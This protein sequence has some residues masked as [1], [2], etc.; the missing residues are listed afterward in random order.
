M[1]N[2]LIGQVLERGGDARNRTSTS[3]VREQES[4]AP[5]ASLENNGAL[6]H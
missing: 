1:S 5:S 4:R 6:E 2:Q 3:A